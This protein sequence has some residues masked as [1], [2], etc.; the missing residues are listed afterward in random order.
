MSSV[1]RERS[2]RRRIEELFTIGYE[3]RS[4]DEYL[5]ILRSHAVAAIVDVRRNPISRKPGFSKS[6]L[7]AALNNAGIAYYHIPEL[8]IPSAE[9]RHL[10]TA[11]DYEAL[12]SRYESSLPDRHHRVVAVRD[13]LRR[14]TRVALTCFERDHDCCHRSRV[15]QYAREQNLAPERINHL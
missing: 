12:L 10:R 9:R 11:A 2:G 14:H 3:K 15:A 7:Q 13:I 6:G 4:L 1:T 5:E 8:G